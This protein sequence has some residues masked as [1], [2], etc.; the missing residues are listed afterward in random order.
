[1]TPAEILQLKR[2]AVIMASTAGN[3]RI[4]T[5]KIEMLEITKVIV[6]AVHEL[7]NKQKNEG[8]KDNEKI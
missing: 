2:A 3:V 4:A 5:V 7:E 1:M 8:N 6:K